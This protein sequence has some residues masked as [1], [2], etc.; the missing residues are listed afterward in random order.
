MM[1][2]NKKKPT[3]KDYDSTT[4]YIPSSYKF[5]PAM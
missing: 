2:M 4:L 1:D 5:T 3:D